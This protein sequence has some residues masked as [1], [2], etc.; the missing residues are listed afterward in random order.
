M[1]SLSR[2]RCGLHARAARLEDVSR[3]FSR[4]RLVVDNENPRVVYPGRCRLWRGRRQR[5][6]PYDASHR[7]SQ[8][9]GR[10]FAASFAFGGDR[11]AVCFGEMP[12]DGQTEAEAAM[13]SCRGAVGLAEAFEDMRQKRRFD[14]FSRIAD[15][16]LD[17]RLRFVR[18][19]V[20]VNPSTR[21]C[22]PHG[23]RQQIPDDLLKAVGVTRDERLPVGFKRRREAVMFLASEAGRI[24]ST[25][26]VTTA[27]MSTGSAL[28]DSFPEMM[29]ETS[30]SSSTS[31]A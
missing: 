19:Q 3:Q 29:R 23:V 1:E 7:Q 15:E 26:A 12:D 22:E 8:A 9:E 24:V 6:S 28:I 21:R 20:D 27:A 13:L 31:C 18:T 10:P 16:K 4:I 2:R 11:A 25:A 17:L 5:G 30:S 14:A